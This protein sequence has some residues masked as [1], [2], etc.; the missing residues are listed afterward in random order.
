MVVQKTTLASL[1][2]ANAVGLLLEGD[3]VGVDVGL[4]VVGVE[5]GVNVVG[6]LLGF[7][8]GLELGSGHGIMTRVPVTCVVPAIIGAVVPGT[9]GPSWTPVAI[10]NTDNTAS[11]LK[12][13]LLLENLVVEHF[14]DVAFWTRDLAWK[15]MKTPLIA[16]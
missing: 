6:A 7:S 16:M 5:E 1:T 8:D 3:V 13:K 12:A 4:L 11:I 2:M 15:G 10:V 9:R 14:T